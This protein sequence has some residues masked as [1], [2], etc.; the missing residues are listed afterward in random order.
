MIIYLYDCFNPLKSGLYC[1]SDYKRL[2]IESSHNSFNPLKSGLY[3]N[4][5]LEAIANYMEVKPVS[6]PLNRFYIVIE[7]V[8]VG[9]VLSKARVSIPLNRVYIVIAHKYGLYNRFLN[10]FQKIFF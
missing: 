4:P 7:E 6:I 2:N 1:N 3:C 8:A 5:F 10:F 9:K